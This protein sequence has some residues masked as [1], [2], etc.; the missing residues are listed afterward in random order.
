MVSVS[1]ALC[2]FL[3]PIEEYSQFIQAGESK[4]YT[5]WWTKLLKLQ[6]RA[7]LLENKSRKVTFVD[8]CF[9]EKISNLSL[10]YKLLYLNILLLKT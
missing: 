7:L 4:Q 9:H 5:P 6:F 2:S 8:E 1:L 3:T 10:N